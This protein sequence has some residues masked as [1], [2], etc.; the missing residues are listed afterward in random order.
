MQGVESQKGR[1][2]FRG[3]Q[4][5]TLTDYPGQIACTLFLAGCNFRCPYCYNIDL[6]QPSD[7][8]NCVSDQEVLQFLEERKRFLDGICITG[9]EPLLHHEKL[10]PF[11]ER[12]RTLG[13]KIKLDTN[14]SLPKA[15]DEVVRARIVDYI[16]MDIKA[17]LKRYGEVACAKV[18]LEAIQASVRLIRSSGVD[19]EFR[20]TVFSGLTLEDFESIGRWLAGSRKYCLQPMR[21]NVPLLDPGFSSRYSSPTEGFMK[22]A[23]GRLAPY[24]TEVEVRS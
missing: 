9:G 5:T 1:L 16:A 13:F 24:F 2:S 11:L 8:G 14:G 12:V 15:V 4:K 6:V 22:E 10:V 23:A 19:Y 7:T 3:I 17:P 18:D 21:S 20:T